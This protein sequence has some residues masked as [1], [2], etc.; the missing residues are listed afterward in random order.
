[1]PTSMALPCHKIC[2]YLQQLQVWRKTS[3]VE[4]CLVSACSPT[5]SYPD[6]MRLLVPLPRTPTTRRL[7]FD[8]LLPADYPFGTT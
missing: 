1:M 8:I 2:A 3:P 7:L 5:A 4:Y 6:L